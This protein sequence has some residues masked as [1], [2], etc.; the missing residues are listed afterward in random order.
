MRWHPARL[1][2]LLLALAPACL[3]A[4]S[5]PARPVFMRKVPRLLLLLALLV[6]P[7][8]ACPA[9]TSLSTSPQSCVWRAGD[10]PAWASPALDDSSWLPVSR[11]PGLATP[12]SNFWLR[13]RIDPGA[14]APEV[15]PVLQVSGDLSYQLFVDGTRIASFG[16]L[17][18]GSHETGVARTYTAPEFGDRN[19]PFLVAMRMTFAGAIDGQQQLPRLEFGDAQLL[20]GNYIT[21]VNDTLRGQWITWICYALITAAGLFF[22]VLYWFDRT[23]GYLLWVSLAW[24]SLAVLRWNEMLL[25]ASVHYPS[26]LEFFLFGLGQAAPVFSIEFFFALNFRRVNRFFRFNQAVSVL[27]AV[28]ILLSGFL[29]LR[30]GAPLFYQ[31]EVVPWSSFVVNFTMILACSAP[32]FAFSPLRSLRGWRLPLAVVCCV[33]QFA[34]AVYFFVQ[35][36]F[37]NLSAVAWYLQPYRAG[38]IAAAVVCLTLLLVQHLRQTHRDHSSLQGELHAAGQIQQLLV[39][40]NLESIPPWKLDAAFRPAQYVGGDFYH[41]PLLPGGRQRILLGDVSG[42]GTAA[43]LTATFLIGASEGHEKDSPSRLLTHL[44]RVLLTSRVGGFSTCICAEISSDGLFTVANA[45]HLAPYLNGDEVPLESGLP[46]GVTDD[47]SYS[48]STFHL[49]PGDT[50]TFLSDGVVEA[51]N[52]A[53]ELFGFDR[54]R[55]ISTRPA[56]AI[57]QA[58]QA[59]GQ[60]DDITVLTFQ[61]APAEVLRA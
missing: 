7:S 60:Q 38:A 55:T 12:I 52:A 13:C 5:A 57:A 22:F 50:I 35:L 9:Q 2:P 27:Y 6:L 4:E 19:H 36:P 49:F 15:R 41:C 59:F 29:P 21:R 30:W 47:E 20:H 53:G 56:A 37:L 61:F 46:L 39:P 32:W 58:A 31:V 17:I 45:G 48:E 33:W 14:L 28:C 3:A 44:S 24:L 11:W 51:R 8:F 40:A 43:A 18:T 26:R 16:N 25:A 23:Q 10:N 34:D 1:A 54:T 42:K